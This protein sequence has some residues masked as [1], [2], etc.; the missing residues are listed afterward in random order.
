MLTLTQGHSTTAAVQIKLYRSDRKNKNG[1]YT[2]KVAV[3]EFF[4]FRKSNFDL[5]SNNVHKLPRKQQFSPGL[6]SQV[7]Y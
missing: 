3:G 7:A 5:R 2:V 6:W 1:T 4:I